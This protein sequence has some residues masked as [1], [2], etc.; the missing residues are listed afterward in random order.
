MSALKSYMDFFFSVAPTAQNRPELIIRSI[1]SCIQ[2]SVGKAFPAH[3][4]IQF[5]AE[6]PLLD[7]CLVYYLLSSV[8]YWPSWLA[9]DSRVETKKKF[10]S[11]LKMMLN[12]FST[13]LTD[14]AKV[15]FYWEGHSLYSQNKCIFIHIFNRHFRYLS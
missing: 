6:S 13:S 10:N 2:L 3:F 14:S 12:Y 9:V 5:L 1:D 8:S 11:N 15:Q 7:F 4:Q